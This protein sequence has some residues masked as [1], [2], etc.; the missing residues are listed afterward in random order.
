M[1]PELLAAAPDSPALVACEVCNASVGELRR[2][3]C[4]GCYS[5]WVEQRPVGVGARCVTCGEKRRRV[6]KQVELYGSWKPMCFNCAGQLLHLEPLPPTIAELKK[7]VSR[8][9]REL[10]RRVGKADTRV[11]VY[12]RRVGDRRMGREGAPPEIDDD[13][14]IEI[15]IDERDLP[16]PIVA[17]AEGSGPNHRA[18]HQTSTDDAEVDFE[19]DLTGI[20]E[21]VAELRPDEP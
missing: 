14:I 15:T 13:M 17:A 11:F 2:G 7:V 3:R 4:W 9:R 1:T 18:S 10:D 21:L 19:S 5:R 6:L 20:R 12:E 16:P 8:E